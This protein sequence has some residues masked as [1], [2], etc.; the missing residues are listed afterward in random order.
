M[1]HREYTN[2]VTDHEEHDTVRK[3]SDLGR[4]DVWRAKDWKREWRR[5]DTREHDVD[6]RKEALPSAFGLTLV[7]PK[8]RFELS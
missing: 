7:A 3:S 8:I 6:G 4:T 1:S 2:V 5:H